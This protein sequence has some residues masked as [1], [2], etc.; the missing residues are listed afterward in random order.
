MT[1][2]V[3]ALGIRNGDAAVLRALIAR[4]GSAVLA[5]CERA[6]APG[7]VPAAAAEAFAK[8]RAVVVAAPRPAELDPEVS[9]LSATRHAA[10]E[11]AP[12]GQPSTAGAGLGRLLGGKT[13]SEQVELVPELLIARADGTLDADGEEQLSRLLDG[14]AA[15]RAAEERFRNA[16]HAYRTA[17]PR[18]IP[19]D[20]VDTIV[21]AMSSVPAPPDPN[22]EPEPP[23]PPEPAPEP[24]RADPGPAAEADATAEPSGP[25]PEEIAAELSAPAPEEAA[26][27]PSAPAPEEAAAELS[28]PAPEE[29]AAEQ[30]APAPEEAAATDREARFVASAEAEPAVGRAAAAVE[31]AAA[32]EA[33]NGVAH[34][35]SGGEGD[36]AQP[37]E[38]WDLS[39]EELGAEGSLD[40]EIAAAR[41][42]KV[43]DEDLDEESDEEEEAQHLQTASGAVDEALVDEELTDPEAEAEEEEEP[44]ARRE[45]AAPVLPPRAPVRPPAAA[46]HP[47]PGRQ[48]LAPA[49]AVVAIAGVSILAYSGVF[50]GNDAQEP[51]DTGIAEKRS[52]VEVPEGEAA[53]VIEELRRAAAEARRQRLA[54]RGAVAVAPVPEPSAPETEEPAAPEGE[55]PAPADEPTDEGNAEPAPQ[56]E[57]PPAEEPDATGAGAFSA[58]EPAA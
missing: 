21:T 16:E 20:V 46:R 13:P 42:R 56:D 4:R 10:A 18:T 49:A 8:F 24:L 23:E 7:Q 32:A 43:T 25:A 17:P 1:G 31:A 57:E 6:C 28:A 11:R 19:A 30:S 48:A 3:T 29:A 39:S 52:L 41:L 38:E 54:D 12:H 9:L 51:V 55:E 53:A 33:S 37:S 27:E 2:P 26:A 47:L 34:G 58:D 15:A 44:P 36:D 50:G 40:V 35:G 22:A 14:S 5:Y 45:P